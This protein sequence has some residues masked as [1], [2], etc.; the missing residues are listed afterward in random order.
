VNEYINSELSKHAPV[1]KAGNAAREDAPGGK[2]PRVR[3]SW[4]RFLFENSLDAILLTSPDGGIYRANQAACALFGC[5]EEEFRSLGRERVLEAS[6]PGLIEAMGERSTHGQFRGESVLI[7]RDGTRITADVSVAH[8]ID[9]E[10]RTRTGMIIRDITERKRSEE[11][12]ADAFRYTRAVIEFSPI[13][14][15]TCTASGKVVSANPAFVRM[16]GGAIDRILSENAFQLRSWKESGVLA[17]AEEALESGHDTSLET[18]MISPAGEKTIY[19]CFFVP[20]DHR[21]NQRL[22]ILFSD[23][24]ERK[25]AEEDL[26]KSREEMRLLA[27][28]LT[29][30]REAERKHLARE[31]HDRLGQTLAALKMD[32]T[33]I[34]R[35]VSDEKRNIPRRQ[36]AGDLGAANILIDE[37]SRT[38]REIISELRP[39][40][41]DELGLPAALAWEAKRFEA[42]T[43][44]VCEFIP[45]A[46]DIRIDTEKSI[47]LYRICQEALTNVMRHARASTV[48]I[49]LR[50][51]E[52][53]HFLEIF[54]NGRGMADDEREKPKTF[55]LLGM[56]ERALALGGS[57]EVAPAGG[58]GTAVTVRLPIPAPAMTGG[59]SEY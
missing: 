12:M 51:A 48:K 1:Q 44:I 24:S 29:L 3:D 5:S 37:T 25:R 43:G 35:M 14:I 31:F 22:L 34:A 49:A 15:L 27:H 19:N 23:I 10:G 46:A 20:F 32:L 54:D 52:D 33:L 21:G 39:P 9:N 17:A 59:E 16:T 45:P 55:G 2:P 57:L 18:G 26:R 30:M 28:N 58:G 7:R 36:I 4:Y 8:F 50:R 38:I 6:D 13:G 40:L 42:R 53:A 11:R 47:A 41:I 56:R